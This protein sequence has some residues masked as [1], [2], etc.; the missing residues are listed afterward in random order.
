MA[1]EFVYQIMPQLLKKGLIEVIVEVP[2]KFKAI[3]MEEAYKFLFHCKKEES[4][5]LYLKAMK[6]LKNRRKTPKTHE[7]S[8]FHTS[9]VPTRHPPD[10]R[11]GEEYAKAQKSVDLIFPIGK[12][13]QWSQYYAKTCLREV[14]K[15]KLKMRIITQQK[16]Q[17][18]LTTYP[19]IY[20]Q[21]LK[22]K[23]KLVSFKYV[24]KPFSVEMQ[25]FDNQVLFVST[26]K[27]SNINKMI[28]FRTTNPLLLEMANGYFEAMWN[29]TSYSDT[30]K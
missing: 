9:L 8:R 2:K 12:F 28:W 17:K 11:I 25:K 26:S 5:K 14:A 3:P 27:N 7:H 16:L 19:E 23:L 20:T 1:R 29:C 30:K 4:K 13:L 22:S 21:S 15:K 10:V 24:A 18:L 6:A